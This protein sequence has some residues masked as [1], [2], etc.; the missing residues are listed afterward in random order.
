M[1]AKPKHASLR[2][3]L[4]TVSVTA[5]VACGAPAN[6]RAAPLST[7]DFLA[8]ATR[9]AP[10][11]P[12][13][14]LQAVAM[15]ESGLDPWILHDNTTGLS[16]TPASQ[17]MALADGVAWINRGDSVDVGLMQIN[18]ANFIA[19]GLSVASALDPCAALS[20]GAA[21][22]QAAYGGGD[23][24]ADQ[25]AALLMALSRYNTGSPLKGIMN[26]Y[27]RAVLANA[28]GRSLPVPSFDQVSP[29]VDPNAPPTWNVSAMAAYAQTH[30][31]PWM[32]VL[33]TG[34][35]SLETSITPPALVFSSTAEA[36]PDAALGSNRKALSLQST[37]SQ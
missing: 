33:P 21:I 9:C 20:G 10:S 25:Q 11:V 2:L 32:V 8:L 18:S 5:W 7:A 19:L 27:A 15:T 12:A 1:S 35:A 3:R 30:G 23:T 6:T 13:E 17:D 37:R 14:T 22:L 4:F 28:P 31:A 16:E 29:A 36:A 34:P 24:S 26:G